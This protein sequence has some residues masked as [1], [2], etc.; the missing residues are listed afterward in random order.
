MYFD[1]SVQFDEDVDETDS[2]DD[3]C[4]AADE[5]KLDFGNPPDDEVVGSVEL[6]I[7]IKGD[8]SLL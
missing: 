2:E 3:G 7:G 1:T 4:V 8:W 6:E 5:V